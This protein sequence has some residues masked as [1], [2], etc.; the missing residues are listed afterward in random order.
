[1]FSA[2]R[3]NHPRLFWLITVL[4]IS[5]PLIAIGL[6]LFVQAED[7]RTV[8]SDL[9]SPAY[10]LIATVALGIAAIQSRRIS[11]RVA[12]GWGVL[13]LAQFSFALGDILWAVIE[14]YYKSSPYPS[15]ADGAYL[16]FY[17]LFLAGIIILPS[18]RVSRNEWIK[19][20]LD[21]GIVMFASALGFWIFLIG[22][23]IAA[24]GA[25]SVPETF[26]SVAYP[27]GDLLI[28]LA[29][30]VMM[31]HRSE[32]LI[33]GPIWF[34]SSGCLVMIIADSIYSYQSLLDIYTSGGLLDLA[35]LISYLLLAYAGVYQALVARAYDKEHTTPLRQFTL[36]DKISQVLAFMPY[37][38]VIGAY[39]LL[40]NYHAEQTA[41]NS[42]ALFSGV[43]VIIG[44]VIFRQVMT[45]N[46]NTH[47]L[48]NL[49]KA[50]EQQNR[51]ASEMIKT[52]H[53]LQQEIIKRE[54]IEQKLSHDALHDGLTGLANRALFMDRLGH[55]IEMTRRETE[56]HYSVLFLDIDNFKSINDGLGHLSGDH[57]LVE[58]AHRLRN[59]TR[60][61]DTVARFGGDEFVIL[62]ENTQAE[63]NA[64]CVANRIIAEIQ[65]PFPLK[66]RELFLSCSIGIVEGISEYN[67]SEDILRDVD[68][69]LYRA[70]EHG[71]S[72]YE[73]FDAEMRTLVISHIELVADLRQAVANG[74][75]SLEYQPI[76]S[77][78]HN[79]IEGLEALLR[80][81]HPER[82]LIMPSEFIQ[83]AEESGLILQIGDWVL[84][85]A[86]AQLVN[87]QSVYPNL[88][89]LTM[90]VN[91]SGK[92]INQKDFVEK[93]KGTLNATGLD[94][95]RLLLE[96]TENAFIENQAYINGLLSDLRSLGVA[97]A[98]DDFGTG[99]SSLGYLQ[100]FS[101][102]TIKID[103]SFVDDIVDGPKGYEIVKNIIRM[104]H[105]LGI[106]T[107]AEGIEND[108]QQQKLKTL[109]CNYGQGHFL[110]QPVDVKHME[111]IL[112][113][114]SLQRKSVSV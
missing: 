23:I 24:Q 9:I 52:N 19:R 81:H 6:T 3:K 54:R 10:N 1:L 110:A 69:A 13:A 86:C 68:I 60:P 83:T 35:W 114:V 61:I 103:R 57:I 26:L 107:V 89:L 90:N 40:V 38:W 16:L 59:C 51:H 44:M 91:I 76:Y 39:L 2:Y 15:I 105:G 48:F 70:K 95:A 47:L 98:I 42:D 46:E 71:K 55:A 97:F 34:L 14:L 85:H 50:L 33:L 30:L 7:S 31:Y 104:A 92:Q 78:E 18:R 20:T 43:G 94:P 32:K 74:E 29:L 36:R 45:L 96:I 111:T 99:Y 80:W 25:S 65:H 28:L 53:N 73:I 87:W 49:K 64:V 84:H 102:N 93:V 8:M 27:V 100:N 106:K 56:F 72:R 82:G 88:E 113:A 101:V 21:L 108:E 4:A 66:G 112:S 11:R 12:L 58:F 109:L 37:I 5:L 17:P 67:N 22:P 62:L 77:L 41:I 63:N 79:V 75:F